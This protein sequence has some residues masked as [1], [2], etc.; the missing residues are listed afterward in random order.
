LKSFASIYIPQLSES[1]FFEESEEMGH[2]MYIENFGATRKLTYKLI[3]NK[4]F[5]VFQL[6]KSNSVSISGETF[7]TWVKHCIENIVGGEFSKLVAAQ[8]QVEKIKEEI[9]DWNILFQ[10]LI[11]RLPNT[12]IYMFYI[13]ENIW[14]GAS[15]EL[16]GVCKN[17]T[18]KTISL[19]GTRSNEDFTAKEV[20]EQS[21]V[22]NF[23]TSQFTKTID[24]SESATR[25]LPF[26]SIQHL[27]N[28]YTFKM[29]DNFDFE[30]TIQSIHP[31]P[32]LSGMPKEKS[33]AFILEN[34]PIERDF[35]SGLV[36]VTFDNEKYSFATI[37]CARFSANQ[38]RYYAGA[39]ITID[40]N[41]EEEWKET[42]NKIDVLKNAMYNE[43]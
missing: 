37:R 21:I 39:G 1:F 31:S 20:E 25:I 5:P 36:S 43:Y 24:K 42:L 13:D 32:A 41:P 11:N 27:I 35:Y 28:E 40:S 19:A 3:T 22:S 30:K 23:I 7:Q 9:L 14:L 17:N 10:N 34:E 38:V 15:P 29:D 8:Y 26:G 2:S 6:K 33:V 4:T 18:F 12:F 16:V